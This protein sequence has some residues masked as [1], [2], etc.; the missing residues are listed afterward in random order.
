MDWTE[1]VMKM[2]QRW[3]DDE[4]CHQKWIQRPFFAPKITENGC[5]DNQD[6]KKAIKPKFIA[7]D[8]QSSGPLKNQLKSLMLSL[9]GY[10][11]PI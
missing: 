6:M 7:V 10:E 1:L 9:D 3:T 8:A 4:K 2:G 5:F 11:I